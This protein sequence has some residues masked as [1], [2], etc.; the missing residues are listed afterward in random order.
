MINEFDKQGFNVGQWV[1][2]GLLVAAIAAVGFILNSHSNLTTTTITF[3]ETQ[4][5]SGFDENH[6]YLPKEELLGFVAIPAGE[7]LMGSDPAIDGNAYE[8]ERWS[9]RLRRGRVEVP[10]FYIGKFEVTVAQ[11][12]AF[13]AAGGHVVD[14]SAISREPGY[15]ISSVTWADALAYCRWLTQQMQASS[16]LPHGLQEKLQQGWSITLP[17]EAQWEKAAR[18]TEG[19]IYPWGNQANA[20]LA[21]FKSGGLK[22][23]G[24]TACDDCSYGL[25]DMSGNVWELT[26]SFYLPYPFDQ[27]QLPDLESDALIVMRGGSYA[28]TENNVRTAVRG[29]VDPGVRNEAIGFRIVLSANETPAQ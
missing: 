17:T 29:G 14:H 24:S 1:G 18:G 8:N 9:N 12:N 27:N 22:E 23:V 2:F 7:F 20:N 25:T 15:P 21:N 19:R 4:P 11:F 6:W 13:I 5:V 16:D 28:D 10:E 26:R 3:P